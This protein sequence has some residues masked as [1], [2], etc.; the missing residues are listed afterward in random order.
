M[1]DELHEC[2]VIRYVGEQALVV[3]TCA[4]GATIPIRLT[5]T[6]EGI[7]RIS[8]ACPWKAVKARV[9]FGVFSGEWFR[10]CEIEIM[11]DTWETEVFNVP[12]RYSR[13][14]KHI[15]GTHGKTE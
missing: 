1:G 6:P 7:A 5:T 15:L 2:E 9:R 12:Q 13:K 11:W 4:T 3:R 8:G 10:D 14:R